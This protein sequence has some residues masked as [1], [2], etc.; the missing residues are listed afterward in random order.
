MRVNSYFEGSETMKE[1]AR[2]DGVI[3]SLS[4]NGAALVLDL[5]EERTRF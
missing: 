3:S 1:S 2:G 5:F 4:R